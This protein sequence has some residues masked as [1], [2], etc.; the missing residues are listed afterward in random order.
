MVFLSR[1][2]RINRTIKSFYLPYPKELQE[3]SH[4][5]VK[6]MEDEVSTVTG[7]YYATISP[8]FLPP[9]VADFYLHPLLPFMS[10]SQYSSRDGE[11]LQ[12]V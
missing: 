4:T 11:P 8:H 12:G 1:F 10:T 6:L 7:S 9:L 5:E 2:P 3:Y